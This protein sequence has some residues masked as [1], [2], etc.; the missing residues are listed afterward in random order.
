MKNNY[1][2]LLCALLGSHLAQAQPATRNWRFGTQAGLSFPASGAPA[3][4]TGSALTSYEA[5]SAVSDNAGNLLCYTNAVQVWDRTNAPMPNGALPSSS[6]SAT[7]GALLLARP[8]SSQEFYLFTVDA[9][10]NALAAGLHYS[11]VDMALRGGLGDIG[12]VKNVAV[13]LP[14]GATQ[15]TE[16]LT[17]VR[18]PNSSNYWV[19]VHGWNTD[20]FYAFLLTS[21]GLQPTPVV[22]AEG[23]VHRGGGGPY[24]NAG[25][26]L[27]ASPAS[28]RLAVATRDGGLELFDFDAATGGVANAQP[29]S[30]GAAYYYGLDFS[31]DGSKL[32]LSDLVGSGLYQID[33]ANANA[34]VRVG[35]ANG[36]TGGV[37]RGNDG[38]IYVGVEQGGALAVVANPNLAGTACGF[39]AN[40][41][42]LGAGSRSR[43]GLPNFPN[44]YAALVNYWTGNVSTDYLLPA[45]WNAG[46]VP[47][48]TDDVNIPAAAVRMPILG[49]PVAHHAFAIESGASM[50]LDSLGI[51]TLSADLLATG[52]LQGNGTLATNGAAVQQLG[53]QPFVLGNIAVGAAGA[54]LAT[55][56]TLTRVLALTGNLAPAGYQLTLRSDARNTA[57]VVNNGTATVTGPATVQRFVGP[58]AY[59]GLGYRHVAAPVAGLTVGSLATAG[60]A[61]VL[62]SSYNTVGNTAVPFPTAYTYDQTRVTTPG[63]T[64]AD[65]DRGW[66]S[67]ANAAVPLDAATGYTL[68]M[69]AGETFAWRGTLHNGPFA[70]AGLGR[71]TG[72]QAG[73]HF[74]GN[75]YP[76]PIRWSLAFAGATGLDDAV[77]TFQASGQYAGG[78]ASFVNGVGLNG[79]TDELALGRGFFVRTSTAGTAGSLTFTNAARLGSYA[80]PGFQR[81]TAETRPLLRLAL[82]GPA[83]PADEAVA[84]LE[85]GATPGFDRTRDAY[86]IAAGPCSL[87]FEAGA[88]LLGISALPPLGVAPVVLPLRVVTTQ[89]GTYSL[90]V[91]ALLN[92][93][94]GTTV[95]LRD[96]LTGTLTALAP[97]TRYVFTAPATAPAGR[98]FVLI[99]P[100]PRPAAPA[101][102]A[103]AAISLYPNPA[104]DQ[105]W[106]SR[107]A[108][109]A[110]QS[111]S[112]SLLNALGQVVRQ[113]TAVSETADVPLS[114]KGLLP[115]I[116]T[117]RI[118]SAVGSFSR[119]VAV[120]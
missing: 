29:L 27:R 92:L 105:L 34:V 103:L 86:K 7:Q 30:F 94:A 76:A 118:R 63:A 74:L 77:Y 62:N 21:A 43:V 28:D 109:L 60:F 13:P 40:G 96:A 116:Y 72:A 101:A 5:S 112:I 106:L 18:V 108:V 11:V 110:E 8:G 48:A 98:F 83:G 113:Q 66:L 38:R 14:G 97:R 111:L 37:A 19:V 91:G 26:Y 80:N 46:Y 12:A 36:F 93:P 69:P 104:H 115:G 39:Q 44:A 64:L 117:V 51:L 1:F 119:R 87:G 3:P 22:S 35:T 57:M 42:A 50:T 81:G 107:P 2:W 54:A 90:A 102:S 33:L 100:A 45:N 85:A 89:A 6:P 67:P 47:S 65:F 61:P 75:P 49:G 55:D 15:L 71:G 99:N 73:W 79:G 114:V 84:Y 31:A 68:N 78:Y 17:A 53:G 4:A 20:L 70:R 59:A 9:I 16:K 24:N 32:Y 23:Q 10:E 58:A 82:Q 95:Q 88:D 52:T 41:V 120:Q 56:V 25:G